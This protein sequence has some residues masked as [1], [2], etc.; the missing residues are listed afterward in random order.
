MHQYKLYIY[1]F[2][3]CVV[4][5]FGFSCKGVQEPID[6][7]SETNIDLY[8][9]NQGGTQILIYNTK[10]R[11]FVDSIDGFNEYV[12]NIVATNSKNKLYVC[13]R[14][15][16]NNE[17]CVYAVDRLSKEKRIILT[18]RAEI[19]ISSTGLPLIISC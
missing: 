14:E 8:I 1:K 18:K 9:G 17:P 15:S 16:P 2:F 12:W 7:K 11:A 5:L 3:T 19:Y 13:S 6:W 4:F 10:Q